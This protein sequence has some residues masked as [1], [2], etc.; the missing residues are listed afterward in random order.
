MNE[1][2]KLDDL[3]F[4]GQDEQGATAPEKTESSSKLDDLIFGDEV[5][6]F[7]PNSRDNPEYFQSREGSAVNASVQGFTSIFSSVPKFI[8]EM[9]AAARG[10]DPETYQ[11]YQLGQDMDRW[12]KDNFPI[13]PVYANDFWTTKV[14]QGVGSMAGFV[15]GGFAGALMRLPKLL[16]VLGLGSASVSTEFVDDYKRTLEER[17]EEYNLE[18]RQLQ[19]YIG[20]LVGTSEAVPVYRLFNRLDRLSGGGVRKIIAE[21]FKGGLE[22]LTQEVFQSPCPEQVGTVLLRSGA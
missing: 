21:G 15:G 6:P 11:A 8:A 7:E 9:T 17:G 12:I 22:E 2:S 1:G 5:K 16:P 4:S 20:G 19:A 10:E 13:N 14:P 18:D 3:I